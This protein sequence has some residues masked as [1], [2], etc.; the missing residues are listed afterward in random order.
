[1]RFDGV[2]FDLDGTLVD[3]LGDIADALNVALAGLGHPVHDRA[4]V[5]T[6]VGDGAAALVRRAIPTGADEAAVL[7]A[8]KQRYGTHS[9]ASTRPFDGVVE[10]L[11]T[12]RGRDLP[13]AILSNKPHAMTLKVVEAL[14][15]VET[16]AHVLG[17][18]DGVP[19]KPDPTAALA[20]AS[21]LGL[22]PTRCALVGDS[23]ADIGAARQSGMYAVAVTWGFRPRAQLA[24][25]RPD[26]LLDSVAA[27]T[28]TLL[29]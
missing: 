22:D 14:F 16:F 4:A 7:A 13:L 27:L 11:D 18:R 5:A 1:M 19:A 2:I 26:A 10:L 25:E 15:A 23:E 29:A 9:V 28:N 17:Q 20:L 21:Q 12:L 3:S 24:A 8:F 6:M